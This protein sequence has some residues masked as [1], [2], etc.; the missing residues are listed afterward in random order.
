MPPAVPASASWRS[1]GWFVGASALLHALALA[2]F[3]ARLH[4][5]FKPLPQPPT[6]LQLSPVSPP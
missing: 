4:A 1:V 2:A 6:M 3:A 5:T